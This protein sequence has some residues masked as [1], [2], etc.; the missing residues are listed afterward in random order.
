MKK[1]LINLEKKVDQRGY[2]IELFRDEIPKG[3]VYVFSINPGFIRGGHYHKRKIEYFIVFKGK[4]K[5]TI[6]NFMSKNNKIL[7][8]DASKKVKKF[9]VGKN[10]VHWFEN[11][12]K[13][14]AIVL[15]YVNEKFNPEDPDTYFSK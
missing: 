2:L 12:G 5:V 7:V 8:F 3:Q 6:Q 10:I 13:G 14:E 4:V 9:F 1:N 11:I 15:A